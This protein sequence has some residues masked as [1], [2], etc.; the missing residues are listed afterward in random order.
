MPTA[1][2]TPYVRLNELAYDD[3]PTF[4]T[5]SR[6]Y[7]RNHGAGTVVFGGQ[8]LP[9][10]ERQNLVDA[11]AG[12]FAADYTAGVDPNGYTLHGGAFA[13]TPILDGTG[14][15]LDS[16]QVGAQVYTL[17]AASSLHAALV[18]DLAL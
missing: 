14:T 2:P 15:A 3:E 1:L 5:P 6:T 4:S 9:I 13:V 12:V 17:G 18:A 10:A 11:I 16:V 8:T 7:V